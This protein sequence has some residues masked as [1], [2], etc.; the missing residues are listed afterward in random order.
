MTDTFKKI[1]DVIPSAWQFPEITCARIA[2]DDKS[3]QT[4]NFRETTWKQTSK[5]HVHGKQV[6]ILEVFYLEDKPEIDEGPFLKEEMKLINSIAERVGRII[7]R[8]QAEEDLIQYRKHLEELVEKRTNEFTIANKQLQ[9]EVIKHKQ[10]ELALQESENKFKSLFNNTND[11][12]FMHDLNGFF[13]EVNEIAC[14][15]LGYNRNELLQMNTVDINNAEYVKRISELNK[16]IS[17]KGHAIFET[18]HVRKDGSTIPTELSSRIIDF[19][20]KKAILCIGRDITDRKL[21]EE[22]IKKYINELKYSNELKNLFTD[23]MRHDLLNPASVVKGFVDF[24]LDIEKDEEKIQAIK[25]IERNNKKL[26]DILESAAKFSKMESIEELEFKKMDIGL[27]IKEVVGNFKPQLEEKQMILDFAIKGIYISKVNKVIEDVFSNLLSNAIKYSPK[28]SRIIINII[29]AGDEWKVEVTDF[30][31]G[32]SDENKLQVFNRFKR[33]GKGGVKGI[34][35][36]L[37]IVKR[38][39]DLHGGRVGVEDNPAGQGSI[40]WV[41]L[42]KA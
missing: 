17:E 2:L 30:G 24:L 20:G 22:N 5:I 42:R 32:I 9:Q 4:K 31:E 38:I 13:L 7:E 8:R 18:V 39:V 40:F 29:D 1:V 23:I 27:I 10:T 25:T 3:F 26:I 21:A 16:E 12:I 14:K 6:G 33:V 11:A 37:A 36:G 19:R 34:G 41:T 35:L 28:E 15:R